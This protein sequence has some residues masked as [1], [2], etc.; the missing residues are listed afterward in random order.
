MPMQI[1]NQQFQ[2]AVCLYGDYSYSLKR[3]FMQGYIFGKWGT[4]IE[5]L[6]ATKDCS[7][8]IGTNLDITAPRET[9]LK[10]IKVFG[11]KWSKRESY[12]DSG[13]LR[14]S[15]EFDDGAMKFTI[16]I[17]SDPPPSCKVVEEEY[18]VP[19]HK[20]LRKKI[21]CKNG[22]KDEVPIAEDPKQEE[23]VVDWTQVKQG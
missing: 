5:E 11:G 12:G 15:Q 22:D 9:L 7:V 14:Y 10:L 13:R 2:D 17:T 20:A 18:E 23:E 3:A 4:L 8:D 19:A 1:K 6:L 21:V 16:E